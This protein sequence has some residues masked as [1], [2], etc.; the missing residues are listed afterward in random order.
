MF[1]ISFTVR[2]HRE[3]RRDAHWGIS[4]SPRL[5]QSEI[6]HFFRHDKI[7]YIFRGSFRLFGVFSP[8]GLWRG[9]LARTKPH[10]LKPVL[11]NPVN[12]LQHRAQNSLEPKTF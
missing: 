6:P 4:I 2:V 5:E 9:V 11:H 8:F 3:P 10:S 7:N 12:L 1:V